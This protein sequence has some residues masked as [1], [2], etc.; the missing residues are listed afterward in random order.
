MTVPL[1][2]DEHSF[3]M[4]AYKKGGVFTNTYAVLIPMV[5]FLVCDRA[6]QTMV[7]YTI[8]QVKP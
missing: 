1:T 4:T 8:F 5:L 7:T 3:L 2:E 6:R